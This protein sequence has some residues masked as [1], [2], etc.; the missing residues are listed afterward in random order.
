MTTPPPH[1]PEPIPPHPAYGYPQSGS[2]DP[3]AWPAPPQLTEKWPTTA[4]VV[5]GVA[6]AVLAI[7]GTALT[8]WALTGDSDITAA[9]GTSTSSPIPSSSPTPST[10]PTPAYSPTPAPTPTPSVDPSLKAAL[11]RAIAPG[12][13]EQQWNKMPA[14]EQKEM[15]TSYKTFGPDLVRALFLSG[16]KPDNEAYE[17]KDVMGDAFMQLLAK[18]C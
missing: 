15:C 3:A 17:Y 5:T 14:S 12:I 10:L 6:A 11:A 2:P 8:T 7:G 1:S 16:I 9:P 4:K 18:R 13:A